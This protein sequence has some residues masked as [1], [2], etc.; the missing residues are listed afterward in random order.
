[1]KAER[2]R[3]L[4]AFG[5]LFSTLFLGLLSFLLILGYI[6]RPVVWWFRVGVFDFFD[7]TNVDVL[8]IVGILAALA[9]FVAVALV[10]EGKQSGRW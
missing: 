9:C 7:L 5:I 3:E 8:G 2:I 1:M 10:I 6:V 4:K